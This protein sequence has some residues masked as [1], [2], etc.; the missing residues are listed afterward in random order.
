MLT[1][2]L[3]MDVNQFPFSATPRCPIPAN[4]IKYQY[5]DILAPRW[6]DWRQDAESELVRK[7]L[8]PRMASNDRSI[9]PTKS[10]RRQSA[11]GEWLTAP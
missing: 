5:E 10:I 2:Y 8:Q 11:S 6:A 1:S 3:V 9:P 4:Q 7:Q